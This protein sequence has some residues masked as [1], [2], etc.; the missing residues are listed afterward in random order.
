MLCRKEKEFRTLGVRGKKFTILT[1]VVELA[2]LKRQHLGGL[3]KGDADIQRKSILSKEDSQCKSPQSGGMSDLFK[4]QQGSPRYSSDTK[5]TQRKKNY[6][7]ISLI[8]ICAKTLN[9]KLA[10]QIQQ[11]SIIYHG[12]VGFIPGK[13]A[14]FNTKKQSVQCTTLINK[15]KKMIT[16]KDRE[17]TFGYIQYPFMI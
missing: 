8:H 14:G 16:S 17:K 15:G 6:R 1:W 10:K 12:L 2:S 9:K 13:Q 11:P 4:E 3:D 7:P 5:A